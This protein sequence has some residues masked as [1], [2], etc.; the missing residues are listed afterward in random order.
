MDPES[1]DRL[2]FSES[3]DVYF[4]NRIY[5]CFSVKIFKEKDELQIHRDRKILFS[6]QLSSITPYFDFNALDSISSLL[7]IVR[8]RGCAGLLDS[9]PSLKILD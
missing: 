5:P 8:D 4:E 6:I 3:T 7:K 9:Y 2:G 1:P